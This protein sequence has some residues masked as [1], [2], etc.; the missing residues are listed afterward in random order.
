M[1]TSP[2]IWIGLF[3]GSSL[4]GYIASLLGAGVL[5]FWSVIATALGGLAGIYVGYKVD[6]EWI[7]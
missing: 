7:G 3:L 5:S 6:T 4:G 1:R 2:L